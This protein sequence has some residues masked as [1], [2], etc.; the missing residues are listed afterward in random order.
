MANEKQKEARDKASG[1]K[2]KG[3]KPALGGAKAVKAYVISFL[4]SCFPPHYNSYS[5]DLGVYDE[6]LDDFGNDPNDFM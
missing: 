1:K 5:T 3:G 6:A 4:E 2:K